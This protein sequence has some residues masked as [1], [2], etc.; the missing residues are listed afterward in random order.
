MRRIL[1]TN[2]L[3][4]G[5]AS[6]LRQADLAKYLSRRGFVCDFIARRPKGPPDNSVGSFRSVTYWNEPI[7]QKLPANARLFSRA[8]DGSTLIHVSK[9]FPYTAAVVSLGNHPRRSLSVDMEELDG[10]GGYASYAGLYGMR[11]NLL[12]FCERFFPVRGDIVP[13]VSHYLLERMRQ[14]GV[15]KERLLFVPNGYD[16]ESFSPSI[17][18]DGIRE[19]Y[20]L[21][22]SKVVIYVSTFHRF[23]KELHRTALASFKLAS[24]Q[25]PDAKMLMVGGGNLDIRSLVAET[26]LQ[27]KVIAA[28]R[29]PRD[30]IPKMIAASDLAI[31]VISNHPFHVST[32]PMVVPEYM[33]MGKAVVAP[34][35][36]ELAFGLAGGAGL[37][38]ETPDPRLLAEGIVRLLKDDSAREAMGHEALR[39]AR[40]E[41]SYNVLAERL[42][43]AYGEILSGQE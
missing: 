10:Y 20:S 26:G 37:L 28:G 27:E 1:F 12:T 2:H 34:R 14:L 9:A 29:V 25:V 8:L 5:S 32:A 16:D 40:S 19:K 6:C 17:R 21:G 18:E 23:E 33:A 35:I 24:A 4:P 7:E 36:G 38:V 22:D 41:Y 43:S 30:T 42:A 13:C 39:R 31:H 15:A 3:P 11:G